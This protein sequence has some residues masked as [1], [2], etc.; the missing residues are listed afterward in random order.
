MSIYFVLFLLIVI[1]TIFL[2]A[3]GIKLSIKNSH[4]IVNVHSADESIESQ[5]VSVAKISLSD[6]VG[7]AQS[8]IESKI[9]HKEQILMDYH[10]QLM[11]E[12]NELIQQHHDLMKQKGEAQASIDLAKSRFQFHNKVEIKVTSGKKLTRRRVNEI[13]YSRPRF[14][15]KEFS[16]FSR[17][18]AN[19]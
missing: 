7:S 4:S 16:Q 8:R 10:H 13:D 14:N 19:V 3:I 17:L 1:A 18:P 11:K 5:P 9:K 12:H 15:K 2:L 6:F